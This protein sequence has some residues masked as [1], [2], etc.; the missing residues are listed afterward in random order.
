[1]NQRRRQIDRLIGCATALNDGLPSICGTVKCHWVLSCRKRNATFMNRGK[2][3]QRPIL[4]LFGFVGE[5]FSSQCKMLISLSNLCIFLLSNL[6]KDPELMAE[7]QKMMGNPEYQKKMKEMT[8]D[9]KFQE[10]IK[11]TTDMLKDPNAAAQQEAKM[12][13]M[14]KV[15]EDQLKKN[16]GD[17][18]KDAMAAMS[19]PDVMAEMQ[20]MMKDPQFVQQIQAMTKDPNFK[21][22]VDAVSTSSIR[23]VEVHAE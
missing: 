10:G 14:L 16:A 23:V 9:K 2:Y 22:Y 8:K 6:I 11:K 20:K 18:M 4:E 1:M 12:E 5:C 21:S 19:N 15:G 3:V 13:H 17:Q 7:A